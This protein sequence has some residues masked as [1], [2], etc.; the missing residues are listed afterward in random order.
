MR[1]NQIEDIAKQVDVLIDKYSKHY[2]NETVASIA[3]DAF[4]DAFDAEDVAGD[5]WVVFSQYF[6]SQA[7]AL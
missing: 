1:I 4:S 6:P 5:A 3:W 2:P 7:G